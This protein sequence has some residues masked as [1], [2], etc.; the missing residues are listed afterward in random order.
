MREILFRGKRVD[1]GTWTCG[2]LFC[3]WER[4]Y[5]CW[6]TT[7]G[8]PNMEEVIPETVCQF[9]YYLVD[10]LEKGGDKKVSKNLQDSLLAMLKAASG[11]MEPEE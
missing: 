9:I 10:E 5:L 11:G 3:I 1:N 6:G 7:N 2:Y 8:V 4:T